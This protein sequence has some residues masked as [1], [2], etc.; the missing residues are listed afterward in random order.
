PFALLRPDQTG[1]GRLG[2]L[3]V[4]AAVPT[5]D[6]LAVAPRGQTLER[7][8]TDGLEHPEARLVAA[9]MLGREQ[10]VAEE[11][12]DSLQD[13]EVGSLCYRLCAPE[14]EASHEDAEIREEL[15]LPRVEEVVAP[16]D[17]A[18]QRPLSL[19]QA[20]SWRGPEQIEP[21]VETLDQRARRKQ[22]AARGCE[23][24]GERKTVEADAELHDGGGIGLGEL[25]V[26]PG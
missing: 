10:A 18:P 12:L 2:E 9:R 17:R 3:Q 5:A 15:L 11:R 23:L 6:R 22:V 16:P 1:L 21:G 25:E 26:R 19:G 8:V 24:E 13:V 20:R 4:E 7:V 14:R